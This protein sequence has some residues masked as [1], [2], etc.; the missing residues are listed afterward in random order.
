MYSSENTFITS[1]NCQKCQIA[2]LTQSR[3][4]LFDR[5]TYHCQCMKAEPYYGM[6]RAQSD[7]VPLPFRWSPEPLRE[8][9][10][11]GVTG[12]GFRTLMPSNRDLFSIFR[13]SSGQIDKVI[14]CCKTTRLRNEMRNSNNWALSF[15]SEF[16]CRSTS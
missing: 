2:P 14:I 5:L 3:H 9:L 4:K 15:C 7:L 10:F 1:A 6:Y 11:T 13:T 12:R 8:C 16:V